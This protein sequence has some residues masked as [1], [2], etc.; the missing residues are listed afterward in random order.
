MACERRT[1]ASAIA[2]GPC[3]MLWRARK[4]CLAAGDSLWAGGDGGP[5]TGA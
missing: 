1:F 4:S 2:A 5:V 3:A